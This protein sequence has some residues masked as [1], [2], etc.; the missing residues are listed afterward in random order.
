MT[1]QTMSNIKLV[2]KSA[3]GVRKTLTPQEF[4]QFKLLPGMK[5]MVLDETTGKVP[6]KLQAKRT[7]QDLTL[8]VDGETIKLSGFYDAQQ[9]DFLPQG[10]AANGVSLSSSAPAPAGAGEALVWSSV[11]GVDASVV[12]GTASTGMGGNWLYAAL[13]GLAAMGA[14]GGGGGG[15]KTIPSVPGT[16]IDGYLVGAKVYLINGTSKIDTGVVTDANGKFSIQNP[17]NYTVQIEGGT[18]SDTGLPNTMV[19]K[20]PGSATGAFVVTPLTTLIQA[21][22]EKSPAGTTT[23]QAEAA[24]QKALGIPAD[25]DLLTYDPLASTNTTLAVQVQKLAV[26]VVSVISLAE[27]QANDVIN[28]IV[29]NIISGN[30]NANAPLDLSDAADLTAVLSGVTTVSAAEVTAVVSAIQSA[31]SLSEI[32]TSQAAASVPFAVEVQLVNGKAVAVNFKGGVGDTITVSVDKDGTATFSR[33]GVD[34]TTKVAKFFTT[35]EQTFNDMDGSANVSLKINAD[36]GIKLVFNLV[37]TGAVDHYVV[38]APNADFVTFKGDIGNQL[39]DTVGL[40]ITDANPGQQDFIGMTVVT[41]DLVGAE[42]LG[43]YFDKTAKNSDGSADN[44]RVT[45]TPLSDIDSSNGSDISVVVVR[46]GAANTLLAQRPAGLTQD[47]MSVGYASVADTATAQA[48]VS[49]SETGKLIIVLGSES[50]WSTLA[51]NLK[52]NADLQFIGFG[53]ENLKFFVGAVGPQTDTSTAVTLASLKN[54]H[55]D[56]YAAIV[57][58]TVGSTTYADKTVGGLPT[59]EK[60]IADVQAALTGGTVT[61]TDYDT[62]VKVSNAMA[63]LNGSDTGSVSKSISDAIGTAP[64]GWSTDTGTWTSQ[65][66]GLNGQVAGLINGAVTYLKGQVT[67]LDSKIHGAG[68][69]T[70]TDYDTLVEISNA[71]AKLN[72]IGDGSVAKSISDELGTWPTYDADTNTFGTDGSGVYQA[73]ADKLDASIAKLQAVMNGGDISA[74]EYATILDISNALEVLNGTGD[75]SV[76]KSISD[77]L[78]T[79]PTYDADT[80]TF[81]TDG[82]GVYQAVADKLDASIAK[83]QAVLNGGDIS[84]SEYATI[85]DI[86]NALEVLNGTGDGSVA[87]SISDAIGHPSTEGNPAPEGSLW[88]DI[89][90]AI[91]NATADHTAPMAP[92]VSLLHDTGANN[93]DGITSDGR[94]KITGLESG[95]TV[96]YSTTNEDDSWVVVQSVFAPDLTDGSTVY[97]RQLDAAGN[98]SDVTQFNVDLD[99]TGPAI[100]SVSSSMEDDGYKAGT[101]LPITVQFD[102]VV[103]VT[104]TPVLNLGG[105]DR[106]V[107]YYSGS[108]SDTLVFNYLVR[109]PDN[110]ETLSASSLTVVGASIRDVAGNAADLSIDGDALAG[111]WIDTTAPDAPSVDDISRDNLFSTGVDGAN[112][113]ITGHGEAGATITLVRTNTTALVNDQ[114]V[115]TMTVNNAQSQ[116]GLGTEDLVFTQTDAAGN[117]S[118]SATQE[119]TVVTGITGSASYLLSNSVKRTL[120]NMDDIHVTGDTSLLNATSLIA[121]SNGTI[122]FDNIKARYDQA[123]DLPQDMEGVV[124][125][126]VTITGLDF[127]RQTVLVDLSTLDASTQIDYLGGTADEIIMVSASASNGNQRLLHIEGGAGGD[128]V[129]IIE[130]ASGTASTITGEVTAADG[131]DALILVGNIDISQAVV[132]GFESLILLTGSPSK[133]TL[134]AEQLSQFTSGISGSGSGSDQSVVQVLAEDSATTVDLIGSVIEDVASFQM[135]E[136]ITLKMSARYS[137]G[138]TF[139]QEQDAVGVTV[140]LVDFLDADLDLSAS[141]VNF[142]LSG[143]SSGIHVNGDGVL[144]D[145]DHVITLPAVS[146]GQT[147]SLSA[148]HLVGDA[149]LSLSGTGELLVYGDFTHEGTADLTGITVHIN[150]DEPVSEGSSEVNAGIEIGEVSI[151]IANADQINATEITGAGRLEIQEVKVNAEG[152]IADSNSGQALDLE[153]LGNDLYVLVDINS[154]D[155]VLN[156]LNDTAHVDEYALA[157]GV[158]LTVREQSMTGKYISGDESNTLTIEDLGNCTDLNVDSAVNVVADVHNSIDMSYLDSAAQIDAYHLVSGPVLTQSTQDLNAAMGIP[159]DVQYACNDF[160]ASR[161]DLSEHAGETVNLL[162]K[163]QDDHNVLFFLFSANGDLKGADANSG[164]DG[165]RAGLFNV[166]IEDGDYIQASWVSEFWDCA[167][168]SDFVDDQ[169]TLG[170]QDAT[171]TQIIVT[172]VLPPLSDTVIDGNALDA[173]LDYLPGNVRGVSGDREFVYSHIDLNDYVGQTVN[174]LSQGRDGLNVV[175]VLKNAA[176]EVLGADNGSAGQFTQGQFETG[177][178]NVTVNVGDYIELTYDAELNGCCGSDYH[179]NAPLMLGVQDT[180]TGHIAR[181]DVPWHF[182]EVPTLTAK[183]GQISNHIVDGAGDLVITHVAVNLAG[184]LAD[185]QLSDGGDYASISLTQV[186]LNGH[187]AI[188]I[189]STNSAESVLNDSTDLAPVDEIQIIGSNTL[190]ADAGTLD[191]KLV[192]GNTAHVVVS[193][194]ANADLNNVDTGSLDMTAAQGVITFSNVESAQTVIM[195]EDQADARTIRVEAG[196]RLQIED[197]T[198][199]TDLSEVTRDVDGSGLGITNAYGTTY[200]KHG[201]TTVLNYYNG[202]MGT[203]LYENVMVHFDGSIEI[204]ELTSTS[205]VTLYGSSDD[206]LAVF[207]DGQEVIM[208][209]TGHGNERWNSTGVFEMSPGPHNIEIWYFQGDGGHN[210]GLF[211]QVADG[212]IKSFTQGNSSPQDGF[213]NTYSVFSGQYDVFSFNP[214]LI[215]I[216][217][218]QP[219]LHPEIFSTTASAEVI[220]HI[221]SDSLPEGEDVLDMMDETLSPNLTG[222]S[223]DQNLTLTLKAEQATGLKITGEDATGDLDVGGSVVINN[224]DGTDSDEDGQ[225]D[226]V[227]DFSSIHAGEAGSV[228]VNITTSETLNAQT[229]LGEAQVNVAESVTLT[230]TAGQ[231]SGVGFSGLGALV[232]TQMDA[233]AN[234]QSV[235]NEN[236]SVIVQVAADESLDAKTFTNLGPVTAYEILDE[237]VETDSQYTNADGWFVQRVDFGSDTI[238]HSVNISLDSEK[239]LHSYLSLRNIAGELVR[240]VLFDDYQY[241]PEFTDVEIQEGDYLE[242]GYFSKH[243]NSQDSLNL[244]VTDATDPSTVYI[245]TTEYVLGQTGSLTLL[246]DQVSGKDVTGFGVLTIEQFQANTDLSKIDSDLDPWEVWGSGVTVIAKI[247]AEA[248]VV[249]DSENRTA[250][251]VDRFEVA[252]SLTLDASQAWATVIDGSGS[253]LVTHLEEEAGTDLSWITTAEV[254]ARVSG[255]VTFTGQLGSASVLVDGGA[256]LTLDDARADGVTMSG[257]G[258]V[259]V[260]VLGDDGEGHLNADL[261]QIAVTGPLTL[262]LSSTVNLAQDS[263]NLE[264]VNNIVMG[265]VKDLDRAHAMSLQG[266]SVSLADDTIENQES[267]SIAQLLDGNDSTKFYTDTSQNAAFVIDMGAEKVVHALS[268][269]T[270]DDH[271][272]RD[273]AHVTVL[274]SNDGETFVE[275]AS[276]DTALPEE[277]Q[278]ESGTFAFDN[279]TG[280]RYYKFVFNETNATLTQEIGAG[281]QIADIHLFTQP[282]TLTISASDADLLNITEIAEGSVVIV[283]GDADADLL[284]IDVTTLDLHLAT[285][286]LNYAHEIGEGKNLRLTLAQALAD[287]ADFSGTGTLVV[288]DDAI[289]SDTDLTGIA[290]SVHLSFQSGTETTSV[291]SVDAGHTLTL[292]AAQA[293]GQ[294]ISGEGTV[295]I[296]GHPTADVDLSFISADI[297]LSG[298]TGYEIVEGALTFDGHAITLP[299]LVADQSITLDADQLT[300]QLTLNGEAGTL[301]IKGDLAEAQVI[302]LTHVSSDV[303]VSTTDPV[304]DG[305]TPISDGVGINVPNEAVLILKPV[306]ANGQTITGDGTVSVSGDVSEGATVDLRDISATLNFS[307]DGADAQSSIQVG[308]DATLKLWATQADGQIIAGDPAAVQNVSETVTFEDVVIDNPDGQ[309]VLNGFHGFNWNIP[310]DQDGGTVLNVLNGDTYDVSGSGYEMAAQDAGSVVAYNNYAMQPITITRTDGGD[311]NFVGVQLTA[312]WMDLTVTL[313][314]YNNGV[315]VGTREVTLTTATETTLDFDWGD[316]DQLVIS[317]DTDADNRHIVIDDFRYTTSVTGSGSVEIFGLEEAPHANFAT[318]TDTIVSIHVGDNAQV[319][320]DGDLGDS[321]RHQVLLGDSATLTLTASQA[322]SRTISGDDTNNITV[323]SLADDTNLDGL[324][325]DATVVAQIDAVIDVSSNGHLGRVDTFEFVEALEPPS[326]TLSA[327]QAVA[328]VLHISGD[329]T[330]VIIGDVTVDNAVMDLTHIATT[331][332]FADN[333]DAEPSIALADGVTLKVNAQQAD[334]R[335]I[336]NADAASSTVEIYALENKSDANFSGI[337]TAA[338]IYVSADAS[339]FTFNGQ[340]GDPDNHAVYLGANADVTLSATEASGRVMEGDDTNQLTVTSVDGNTNLDDVSTALTL[341]AGIFGTTNL[342]TNSHLAHVD[343]YSLL[344]SGEPAELTLS[345]SQIDGRTVDGLGS[346]I[347]KGLVANDQ[348]KLSTDLSNVSVGIDVT[349][350]VLGNS[351]LTADSATLTKID[352]ITIVK[353]ALDL[354]G[355]TVTA[356]PLEME[357]TADHGEVALNVLDHDVGTKYFSGTGTGAGLVIE[358]STAT[359]VNALSITTANDEFGRNPSTFTVK[360]SVDGIQWVTIVADQAVELADAPYVQSD[361][362]SFSN[363]TAYLYYEVTFPTTVGADSTQLSELNLYAPGTPSLTINVDD[364]SGK[365]IT[366]DATV[367]VVGSTSSSVDLSL[368]SATTLDIHAADIAGDLT[369]PQSIAQDHTWILNAGQADGRD[370][371]GL[372]SLQVNGIQTN[373]DLSGVVLP[374]QGGTNVTDFT[375]AFAASTW[376]YDEQHFTFSDTDTDGVTDTLVLTSSFDPHMNE[377]NGGYPAAIINSAAVPANGELSIDFSFASSLLTNGYDVV[378]LYFNGGDN[379]LTLQLNNDVVVNLVG[380][381]AHWEMAGYVFDVT[382]W[383]V[384]GDNVTGTVVFHA[385]TGQSVQLFAF[386]SQIDSAITYTNFAFTPTAQSTP[387]LANLVGVINE[388]SDFADASNVFDIVGHS[389]LENMTAY[390]I[391]GGYTLKL[392]SAQANGLTVTAGEGVTEAEVMVAD[393][394]ATGASVSLTNITSAVSINFGIDDGVGIDVGTGGTLTLRTDQADQ[395]SISGNGTVAIDGDIAAEIT[396]DLRNV[397]TE[398]TFQTTDNSNSIQVNGTLK[399]NAE[400]IS[401]AVVTGEGTVEVYGLDLNSTV[402][403][404]SVGSEDPD[405]LTVTAMIT[406]HTDLSEEAAA[407]FATVDSYVVS[408]GVTLTLNAA[409]ANGATVTDALDSAGELY[410]VGLV[411]GA[412]GDGGTDLT[413]VTVTGTITVEVTGESNISENTSLLVVD[414][415]HVADGGVLTLTAEQADGNTVVANGVDRTGAVVITGIE[416][417]PDAHLDGIDS[418][419]ITLAVSANLDPL[420]FTGELGDA[421]VSIG[422]NTSLTLSA[423]QA[424]GRVVLGT[425]SLVVDAL[426]TGTNLSNVEMAIASLTGRITEASDLTDGVF[427]ITSAADLDQVTAYAIDGAYTLKVGS[428]VASGLT[429]YQTDQSSGGAVFVSD[430]VAAE[431][432]IDLTS[433]ESS[434]TVTFGADDEAGIDVGTDGL[435]IM[436][437]DQATAQTV[438][439]AGAMRVVGN[440]VET[441]D[442]SKAAVG[443]VQFDLDNNSELDTGITVA[444]GQTLKIGGNQLGATTVTVEGNLDVYLGTADADFDLDA[445]VTAT[446]E[447]LV[448]VHVTSNL[449]LSGNTHFTEI[450]HFVVDAEVT[451]TLDPALANDAYVSGEGTVHVTDLGA[452]ADALTVNLADLTASSVTATFAANTG[453]FTGDLGTAVVTVTAGAVMTLSADKANGHTINGAV[454]ESI[455]DVIHDGGSIVITGL[456]ATPVDLSLITAGAGVAGEPGMPAGTFTTTVISSVTIDPTTDLGTLAIS[457]DDGMTFGLTADQADLRAISGVGTAEIHG[458]ITGDNAVVDLTHIEATLSFLDEAEE[459]ATVEVGAENTLVLNASQASGQLITGTGTVRIADDVTVG[460]VNLKTISANLDFTDNGLDVADGATLQLTAAQASAKTITGAGTVEIVGLAADTDLSN[461]GAAIAVA[462]LTGVLAEQQW[463][464]EGVGGAVA[465]TQTTLTLSST[466]DQPQAVITPG[467]GTYQFHYDFSSDAYTNVYVMVNGNYG[468]RT[469]LNSGGA[470]SGD[471]ELVLNDGDSVTFVVFTG[472]TAEL[473]VSSMLFT[474]SGGGDAHVSVSVTDSVD[475]S[476][477]TMLD[478]VDQYTVTDQTTL[479]LNASEASGRTI[480]GPGTAVIVGNVSS[481]TVDLTG[482]S[483]N[484]EFF[485]GDIT[486]S[487]NAILKVT[488][489][490]LGSTLVSGDGTLE[491]VGDLADATTMDLQA[492][493]VADIGFGDEGIDITGATLKMTATQIQG[494]DIHGAG[495]LVVGGNVPGNRWTM[496]LTTVSTDTA[497]DFADSSDDAFGITIGANSVLAINAAHLSGKFVSGPGTIQIYGTLTDAID[498][499]HVDTAVSIDL[500]QLDALD[501][502]PDLPGLASG[503]ELVLTTSQAAGLTIDQPDA[504]VRITNVSD[505]LDGDGNLN[506]DLSHIT[507]DTVTLDVDVPSWDTPVTVTGELGSTQVTVEGYAQLIISADLASDVTIGGAGQVLITGDVTSGTVNLTHIT[508]DSLSF[509]D[510]SIAVP[511]DATLIVNASQVISSEANFTGP[512]TVSIVGTHLD[513]VSALSSVS[514]TVKNIT[515]VESG[516]LLNSDVSFAGVNEITLAEGTTE[517]TAAQAAGRVF[518]G[519]GGVT[520]HDAAGTQTFNGTAYSDTFLGQ[521]S[522]SDGVDFGK[523]DGDGNDVSGSDTVRFSGDASDMTVTGL[524]FGALVDNAQADVLDF[525]NLALN[526]IHAAGSVYEQLSIDGEI[527]LPTHLT[528]YVIGFSDVTAED[529]RGVANLFSLLSNALNKTVDNGGDMVFLIANAAG[530]TNVWHWHDVSA[531]TGN[532]DVQSGELTKLGT[533]VGVDQTEIAKIE[534]NNIHFIA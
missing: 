102:E 359:V 398:V 34:A 269:T 20:A 448:T 143:L 69:I 106:A 384:D 424:D 365:E 226:A 188:R 57:G 164:T 396:V 179:F 284:S 93:A 279:S 283:T 172:E 23:A 207:I 281:T 251:I 101:I 107:S 380:N 484:L 433:I 451:L 242:F 378:G 527:S 119:V 485:E 292:T 481:G 37:D 414:T 123:A 482:V 198:V 111:I 27:G 332:S 234:L 314:G 466:N 397:T 290:G 307:D 221:T 35:V 137:D 209:W 116:F 357:D 344:Q 339:S 231:A 186:S 29:A 458:D 67:S 36:K 472:G 441:V 176:G 134:T 44:D 364:A 434:V 130:S 217:E 10:E 463:S 512:G 348:Q 291:I 220:G 454:A 352:A 497:I 273:P 79:W 327:S 526:N 504:T 473:S 367:V 386:S 492:D 501:S 486:V 513:E 54:T 127:D 19:L 149:S 169:L 136:N 490:Q 45:L 401:T 161:F 150:F 309:P 439:G 46:N 8:N 71:L 409:E 502:L 138:V 229:N 432:T 244:T 346:L 206:G 168:P 62:L 193:G 449:D 532:G 124:I 266:I 305:E 70:A 407:H 99:A 39:G 202:N 286:D 345:A 347:V 489:N 114:G 94:L 249:F 429:V 354:S 428:A 323:T 165:Y 421:K 128:T 120:A 267:E 296:T 278:T 373:T 531:L 72:G 174:L 488:V 437:A 276:F 457:I 201:E 196:G 15:S 247:D 416:G 257:E 50:E 369:L 356:V 394:V 312:A 331:L 436:R 415:F 183:A 78:G 163:G 374:V 500:T 112:M 86:S 97:V 465:F 326:L 522:N 507:A 58:G 289:T 118:L 450:T 90:T 435:L 519:L 399:V 265:V 294:H 6:A 505:A 189:D 214:G 388:H 89:E 476:G 263:A 200:V 517:F 96:Q 370:I 431:A 40:K 148:N 479:T 514:A 306:H 225:A 320:F 238:G 299:A 455:A 212:D 33:G 349:A 313:T 180:E 16:A 216:E 425:G 195:R 100:V 456:D 246:S 175:L 258:S 285:G 417:K 321:A 322:D 467:A 81:G 3:D 342:V 274:G 329:G 260:V 253:V 483:A 395:Q 310:V 232:L 49:A 461:V 88:A 282:S 13:G 18:N 211:Y 366:G 146:E 422:E 110:A 411:S 301:L 185:D 145:G 534:Q 464:V 319:V 239:N 351:D 452:D 268:L 53:E 440:L 280:Y 495:T 64:S 337:Y 406:D 144:S 477:N 270:A 105:V 63:K 474:P 392:N 259:T 358:M 142:N 133:V 376:T 223:I 420:S 2:V 30:F 311:F 297:D 228:L 317:S 442:L 181:I 362:Y 205:T 315:L 520:I 336:F 293:S 152:Q 470:I 390:V 55:P 494:Q 66:T 379:Q 316:I 197:W 300:G 521:G 230:V 408:D 287:Q 147:L 525:R 462:D 52:N 496:D 272:E 41:K 75:G 404:S 334:G 443:A 132:S 381:H 235:D 153:S 76:A 382:N 353:A 115:W 184:Q 423:G 418:P 412:I 157:E 98:I 85:L 4:A 219:W 210:L 117:L 92:I 25:V 84:A 140:V 233:E 222:F 218:V 387:G 524:T 499:S 31:T 389:N 335:V 508:V 104:G 427:D 1:E 245:E 298:L 288:M 9:V 480:D 444:A 241:D 82:S 377:N 74:S 250:W 167:S 506:V 333:D 59:L 511:E 391:D 275:I 48:Y 533:L 42:K 38:D 47:L 503:Q 498:L 426:Q 518:S 438:T 177:L 393:D 141:N 475:V 83:L 509:D 403:L 372:G 350:E 430:D 271:A 237:T 262:H 139:T 60:Q 360:G 162:L 445:L 255:D 135:G 471:V 56:V 14:G 529:A 460:I 303:T 516:S 510:G 170:I 12:T 32:S 240:E 371:D 338:K 126:K 22:L 61:A 468:S 156:D 264:G 304:F 343:V 368:V 402:D 125:D 248:D 87:K 295:I 95:A 108:G 91:A 405:N 328:N 43:F 122:R 410:V 103:Y 530:N 487:D 203:G 21:Y 7:A 493:T 330:T 160:T 131:G 191:G 80:N 224:L 129:R 178:L 113:T 375:G 453:E 159:G 447:G 528:G 413:N 325:S 459:T 17:N 385:V 158:S 190:Y 236:L 77:E 469:V 109:Y 478:S 28:N 121:R 227:Y 182:S 256:T 68:T 204:T 151:V 419:D 187:V 491:I 173:Q 194:D 199:T 65:G 192:T 261:S 215:N 51:T 277:R 5:V 155:A 340:L 11:A 254:Q 318:I 363:A 171:D 324:S 523:Q 243:G 208:D 154:S 166:T 400:A 361:I 341:T 383:L 302:D 73:V 26:S 24:V 252:G 355:A 515:F 213:D 308:V 446:G